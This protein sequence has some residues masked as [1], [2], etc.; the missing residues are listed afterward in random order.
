MLSSQGMAEKVLCMINPTASIQLVTACQLACSLYQHRDFDLR[1]HS[2]A[3]V[4]ETS[5]SMFSDAT[6]IRLLSDSQ[7]KANYKLPDR[8]L[9]ATHAIYIIGNNEWT[10]GVLFGPKASFLA[11]FWDGLTGDALSNSAQLR[12]ERN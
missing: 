3:E 4:N 7:G 5:F 12:F 1:H 9:V 2:S 6:I 10:K 8:S 11:F